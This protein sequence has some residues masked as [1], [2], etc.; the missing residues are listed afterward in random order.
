MRLVGGKELLNV[1]C[2]DRRLDQKRCSQHLIARYDSAGRVATPTL[3][4]GGIDLLRLDIQAGNFG[5]VSRK[6]LA[7]NLAHVP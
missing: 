5:L 7:S 4:K 1:S 2:G 6:L 3:R